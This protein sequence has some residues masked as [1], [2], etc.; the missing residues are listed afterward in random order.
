MDTD[1]RIGSRDSA[2]RSLLIDLAI[3]LMEAEGQNAVTVRR[4]AEL[5]GLSRQIVHYYFVSMEYLYL[6]VVDRTTKRYLEHQKEAL[7]SSTP[8]RAVWDLLSNRRAVKLEIEFLAL[9]NQFDSVRELLTERMNASRDMQAEIIDQIASEDNGEA[10]CGLP[11]DAIPVYLMGIARAIYL[12]ENL[13]VSRG[14][15]E[16]LNHI[17]QHIRLFDSKWKGQPPS[18]DEPA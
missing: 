9:A 11:P 5:S 4:L 7:R 17:E 13:G 3:D 6:A 1:R 14:H 10:T 18:E 16:A 15:E 8:L 12:E 2:T